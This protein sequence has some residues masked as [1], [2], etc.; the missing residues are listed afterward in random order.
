L[1][2]EG[3]SEPLNS[4]TKR[5]LVV[6]D[7][8]SIREALEELLSSAGHEVLLAENGEHALTVL[9]GKSVDCIVLD[10][11]MPRMDGEA[12]AA[13]FRDHGGAAPIIVISASGDAKLVARRIGAQV[14]FDKPFDFE[15]LEHAVRSVFRCSSSE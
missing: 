4:E 7:D 14:G 15:E 1:I 9:D 11:R 13:R 2:R 6:D 12:F 10:L 3:Q 5:V 8:A